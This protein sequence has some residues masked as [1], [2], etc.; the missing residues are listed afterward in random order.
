MSAD[1]DSEVQTIGA[2]R[3]EGDGLD[4]LIARDAAIEKLGEGFTWSEGPVW[5]PE[6]RYLLFSDVP[7]NRIYRWAEG[8]GISVFLEPSGYTGSDPTIFRE[9]GTNGLIIG[10]GDSILAADHGNRAIALLDLATRQKQFLATHY[11]GKRLNSPNDLVRARDGSI[12]FTDPPYGLT[13][14]NESPHKELG[15]NGVYR[16]RPDGA[17]DL[18][19]QGMSFPNGIILSPDE[20]VLYVAN[21]D[22][23]R[24]I[25]MAFDLDAEGHKTGQR[26]FADLTPM[27]KAGRPGLPDGM[28]I[29]REGNLFATGPG[30][31]HVFTPAGE[32]LGLIE[33]G[34]AVANCAF[35]EDGSTLFLASD[36]MLA[37]VRTL[38]RGAEPNRQPVA[39]PRQALKPE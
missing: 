27:A 2:I 3:R 28:A 1:A 26:V 4:R 7:A 39:Q 6:G 20:R 21:S 12:W 15:H 29:D 22:P 38:T 17:L 37:R 33:T 34:T 25:I 23:E 10:P 16:L 8:E 35:G 13:G 9:P 31:V 32:R 14:I 36:N 5:V 19:E 11:G 18:F 30:G 24:A